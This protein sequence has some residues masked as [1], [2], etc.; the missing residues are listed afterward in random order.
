[1]IILDTDHLNTLKYAGSDRFARLAKR[2]ASSQD[3][4]FVTT[5]ITL[6]EQLRGWLA[7]I[8]RFKDPMKQVPAYAELTGLI[9]FFSY[10]TILPFDEPAAEQFTKYRT[11]KIRTGTM[12]LKIA[13]I[14]VTQDAILL[15]ANTRDFEPIPN[16]RIE[17]WIH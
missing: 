1:M 5:A 7:Q 4:D 17:D 16:L 10:W 13:S 2:M 14:S 6:E 12:D 15:T 3:Q 11:Q 8:N 9:E